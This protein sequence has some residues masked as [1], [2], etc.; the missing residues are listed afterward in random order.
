V[1]FE[2]KTSEKHGKKGSDEDFFLK[3]ANPNA[4]LTLE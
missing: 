4:G 3:R 1:D 2:H